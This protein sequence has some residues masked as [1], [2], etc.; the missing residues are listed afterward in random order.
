MCNKC[1]GC[2]RRF[3]CTGT[4]IFWFSTIC[5]IGRTLVAFLTAPQGSEKDQALAY[6]YRETPFN[7]SPSKIIR[8][9]VD[10][11]FS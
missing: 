6:V 11:N 5:D 7:K 4:E 2:E 1:V 10:W 9:N 8:K 3:K